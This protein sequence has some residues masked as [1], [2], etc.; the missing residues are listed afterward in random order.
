VVAS[1]I[2]VGFADELS[3]LHAQAGIGYV[4]APVFGRPE[5]A[6]TAQLEVLAAGVR[7]SSAKTGRGSPT[8][9]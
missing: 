8:T 9:C 7:A 5:A 3:A 2:S 6:E 1:T 4:A